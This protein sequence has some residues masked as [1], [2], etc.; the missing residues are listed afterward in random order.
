MAEP[1]RY[2]R[3]LQS[4]LSVNPKSWEALQARGVDEHTPLQLDFEYT[5][6]GEDE[7][8]ALM[9]LLR[10]A[11]DYEFQGGARNQKD[12]TQRW[13]V[14][15]STSPATWSLER[16]NALVTEMTAYGRDHGPAVFD[17]WGVRV[18][19]G[20]LRGA[21][22]GVLRAPRDR[23]CAGA[24]QRLALAEQRRLTRDRAP[25]CTDSRA[26]RAA[27]AASARRPATVARIRA[28]M[29]PA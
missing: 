11:T 7:V 25:T 9:R 21:A 28:Q 13:L 5:A 27:S 29:R 12:G 16:L 1:D 18:A 19:R 15:G 24:D 4:H 6:P 3:L 23:G 2:E 26:C 14:L 20:G 17:G 8:R 22:D 10:T